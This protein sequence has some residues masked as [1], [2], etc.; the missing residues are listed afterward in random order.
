LRPP[1]TIRDNQI[2]EGSFQQQK[3]PPLLSVQLLKNNIF[4]SN[5]THSDSCFSIF[6]LSQTGALF[7]QVFHARVETDLFIQQSVPL[8]KFDLQISDMSNSIASLHHLADMDVGTTPE[9]RVK[10][11]QNWP[12]EK[13]WNC[14]YCLI[15]IVNY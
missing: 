10:Q 5:S 1:Y 13:L 8:N 14:K 12:F 9:L 7:S 4:L 15:C 3:L 2:T 11:N 6:Q